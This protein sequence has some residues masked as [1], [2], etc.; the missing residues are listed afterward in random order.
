MTRLFEQ[1]FGISSEISTMQ[2][3]NSVCGKACSRSS[4]CIAISTPIQAGRGPGQQKM[5]VRGFTCESP[6][7]QYLETFVSNF[8]VHKK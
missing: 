6:H 2:L 5:S 3:F 8:S 1:R 7:L 4:V